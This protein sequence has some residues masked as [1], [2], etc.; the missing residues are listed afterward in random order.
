MSSS[1]PSNEIKKRGSYKPKVKAK[2]DLHLLLKEENRSRLKYLL[3]IGAPGVVEMEWD[4]SQEHHI[5]DRNKFFQEHGLNID[6]DNV[7]CKWAIRQST[8]TLIV[9]QCIETDRLEIIICTREQQEYAWKY[10]YQNLILVDETF[11]IS[12]YKL[13]LFIIMIIDDNN[14]DIPISFILF[15]PP[16]SNHLTSPGYDSKILERLFTI[17]RDKISNNYNQNQSL[18]TLVTFSPRAI[19][20]DAN[21]KSESYYQKYSQELFYFFVT[22][23]S[24]N[25]ARMKLINNYDMVVKI[26]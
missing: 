22:F 2:L 4:L 19:M 24:V 12:K 13:L 25:I 21:I 15:T 11:G 1:N 16:R 18:A 7:R 8:K 23:I 20:T 14:K 17:F 3:D 10:G 5:V 9:K 26:K 6:S